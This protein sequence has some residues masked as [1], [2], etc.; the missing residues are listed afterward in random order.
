MQA[1]RFIR[2]IRPSDLVLHTTLLSY[3]ESPNCCDA[4]MQ[5]LPEETIPTNS[6]RMTT[7]FHLTDG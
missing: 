6:V 1:D 2:K 7:A 4:L 5:M 3:G